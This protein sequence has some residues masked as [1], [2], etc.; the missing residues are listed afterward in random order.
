MYAINKQGLREKP[1]YDELIN[2]LQNKQEKIVYPNR[3]FKQLRETPQLSNLLDGEGFDIND[4][5]DQQ[6]RQAKEIAKQLAIIQADG[7]AKLLNTG[8]REPSR[9]DNNI[10][11]HTDS[12]QDQAEQISE[13]INDHNTNQQNQRQ[14]TLQQSISVLDTVHQ[15]NQNVLHGIAPQPSSSSTDPLPQVD[16]TNIRVPR[17]DI[18]TTS[19]SSGGNGASSSSSSTTQP[20]ISLEIQQKIIEYNTLGIQDLKFKAREAIKN[21]GGDPRQVTRIGAKPQLI[22]LIINP[23]FA[24]ASAPPQERPLTSELIKNVIK[25][26]KDQQKNR[27]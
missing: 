23:E 15:Q 20:Q 6:I 26:Y 8:S 21:R 11:D 7:D 22:S 25:K 27:Q 13:V 10:S 14:S 4:L 1:N 17:G 9:V 18:S 5:K 3:F 24:T 16:A 19:T 2:Y 12:L